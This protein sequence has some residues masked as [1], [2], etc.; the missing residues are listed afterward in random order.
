MV[1]A[2][3]EEKRIGKMFD[4]MLEYLTSREKRDKSFNWE[5]VVA[6]DGSRDKT[7]EVRSFKQEDLI[8]ISTA[9]TPK[10]SAG[11]VDVCEEI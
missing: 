1:P 2:Y 8:R 5:V 3:N 10:K 11:C 7:G 6:D 9:N 4:E